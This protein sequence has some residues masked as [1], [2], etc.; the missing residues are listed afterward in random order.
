MRKTNHLQRALL[1]LIISFLTCFNAYGFGFFNKHTDKEDVVEQRETNRREY[2][3][4]ERLSH[5]IRQIAILLPL[6]GQHAEAGVAIR[7]GFLAGYYA[8]PMQHKPNIRVYDTTRGDVQRVYETAIQEGADF[9]VG[10][11]SKEDVLRIGRMGRQLQVPV[12]ALNNHPELYQ[13]PANFVMYTLA[14]ETEAEQI[15]ERAWEKGYRSASIVVPDNAWGKRTAGAF[16]A[17]WQQLGGKIIRSVFANPSQDQAAA[18]RRLLGIDES[19]KRANDIKNLL[20][21]KVEFKA[22][23]QDVD[24]IVMAAPPAQARQLKPLF[25]F[26]Y[27]EDVPVLATSS[28]YS[29]SQNP[30]SDRDVNG[31]V[32]CDMPWLLDANKGA[33]LRQLLNRDGEEHSDQYGRLF[34]M[35]YDAYNLTNQIRVLQ[36]RGNYAGA[37][38][39][40]HLGNNNQIVRNLSWAKMVDGIATQIN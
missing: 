5:E 10:P 23:R 38:G 20:K 14:P 39:N 31:V 17:R 2:A 33:S 40:L 34:A 19:Q 36:G 13:A 7:E 26:Y 4:R 24:V 11:L 9:I 22:R 12:L 16:N 15:A 8:N 27:A 35:G 18:V 25:D 28:I 37:T 21:E 1:V 29:G 32:F 3:P 30:R 6:T